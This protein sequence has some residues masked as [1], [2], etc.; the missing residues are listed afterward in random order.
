MP[1]FIVAIRNVK[2]GKIRNAGIVDSVE[3]HI[4]EVRAFIHNTPTSAFAMFSE[5]YELVYT[6]IDFTNWTFDNIVPFVSWKKADNA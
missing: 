1:K 2:D 6:A 3:D 4:N 5:D